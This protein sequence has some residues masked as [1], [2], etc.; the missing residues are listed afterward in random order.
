[1]FFVFQQYYPAIIEAIEKGANTCYVSY[2]GYNEGAE[3]K[4]AD[5]KSYKDDNSHQNNNNTASTNNATSQPV[6]RK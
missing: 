4:L 5:I 3:V 2:I 1:M 6:A